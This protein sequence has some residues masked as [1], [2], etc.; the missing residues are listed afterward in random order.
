MALAAAA[1]PPL[2]PPPWLAQP[3]A[4]AISRLA[5]VVLE[6]GVGMG[7]VVD[8][9]LDVD[10]C[11]DVE[12]EVDAEAESTTGSTAH[13]LARPGYG[14]EPNVETVHAILPD[15]FMTSHLFL[16]PNEI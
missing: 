7:D 8:V 11:V 6:A 1:L 13:F 12:T 4:G 16:M 10:V 9:K 15:K 3:V 2:V 14:S 5:S